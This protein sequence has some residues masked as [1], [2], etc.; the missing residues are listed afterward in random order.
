[1]TS[2][3][4]FGELLTALGVIAKLTENKRLSQRKGY[5]DIERDSK[6]QYIYRGWCDD[7]RSACLKEIE[8]ITNEAIGLAKESIKNDLHYNQQQQNRQQNPNDP[9]SRSTVSLLT[10][11][12]FLE[13]EY[14]MRRFGRLSEALELAAH[15]I[16]TMK[17]TY[18]NDDLFCSK[19]DVLLGNIRE[20]ISD[21]DL[22]LQIQDK[23]NRAQQ[24]QPIQLQ[25]PEIIPTTVQLPPTQSIAPSLPP[26]PKK[27][28]S[29]IIDSSVSDSDSEEFDIFDQ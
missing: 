29:V 5:V 9:H 21:M 27:T 8:K 19:I 18:R 12:P 1:M 2:E 11:M 20:Q 13:K 28:S 14:N 16:E 17:V 22:A 10:A 25:Q 15:G 23:W 6:F 24:Q 4:R 3:S 26:F 7:N